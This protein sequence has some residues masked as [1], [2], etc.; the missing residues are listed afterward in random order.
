MTKNYSTGNNK[1]RDKSSM[2]M[3]QNFLFCKLSNSEFSE[4][5]INPLNSHKF[6]KSE[7]KNNPLKTTKISTKYPEKIPNLQIYSSGP[8]VI[9]FLLVG[10]KPQHKSITKPMKPQHKSKGVFTETKV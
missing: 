9:L 7:D 3:R 1:I 4:H 5:K 8:V 10:A 6:T 2:H